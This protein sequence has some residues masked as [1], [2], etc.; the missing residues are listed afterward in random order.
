MDIKV[1]AAILLI[2][3]IAS[4]IL[5][6]AVL[7]RQLQLFK[8]P[9]DK[10]IKHYRIILF[11]LALAIFAGNIIPA[12]IDFLTI[13]DGLTRS[14]KTINGVG[15]VYSMAWTATSLLSAIL[16]WW[17]YRMSHNVDESH[18]DSDHTLTNDEGITKAVKK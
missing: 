15:L 14:A 17:L 9:I 11:L 5:M 16:I 6:G 1:Y 8:M 18:K 12:T 3:R 10:E 7:K 13:V 4:M 2:V